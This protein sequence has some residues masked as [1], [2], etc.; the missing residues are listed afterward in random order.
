MPV[1]TS[2]SEPSEAISIPSGAETNL[3]GSGKNPSL[4]PR[5]DQ[6]DEVEAVAIPLNPLIDSPVH[7]PQSP[8]TA[9]AKQIHSPHRIASLLESSSAH[10]R[11]RES[12]PKKLFAEQQVTRGSAEAEQH[13]HVGSLIKHNAA[14]KALGTGQRVPH[15]PFG[16]KSGQSIVVG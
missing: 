6:S 4:S 12:L 14:N 10:I 15:R 8:D 5:H 13:L 1:V 2:I 3:L 9:Y 7:L 11:E 16:S